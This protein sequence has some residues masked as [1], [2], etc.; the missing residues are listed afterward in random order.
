MALTRLELETRPF[1]N[2]RPFGS[3]GPYDRLEGTA[4]FALDPNHPLNQVIVDLEL[5]P[6]GDDGRV[7]FTADFV[8]LRPRETARANGRLL[9]DIPNR[10]RPTALRMLD[11]RP[12]DPSPLGE[13]R[14][15]DGWLLQR[16]YTL[17]CCGWQHDVPA[18]QGLIGIQAPFALE[19]GQPIKG[20]VMCEFQP[21]VPANVQVLASEMA[22][23]AHTPYPTADVDDPTATLTERDYAFGPPR[24]IERDRW[25]FA[26]PD[27]D[28]VVP[29]PTRVYFADGF[30]PGKRYEVVYTTSGSPVTGVGFAA[31]RD[32][33]SFLR[34]A[35][36]SQG[37]PCAGSLRS[38]YAFGASQS[39]RFL[40]HLLYLGLCEDEEGRL[41]FDGLLPHIGGG[42]MTEANWRF[43]Q[44]S[45]LGPCSVINLFPFSDVEQTEP[46]TGVTDGVQSR[47]AARGKLPKVIYTNSSAEYWGSQA[48]LLHT[49]LKTSAD[50]AV[51][52]YTRIYAFAGTQH[53]GAPLPLTDSQPYNA[54]RAAYPL[55]SINYW[56]LVRAALVNLD[57]WVCDGVDPPPSRHPRVDERTA[58]D[59]SSLRK[60]FARLP[61]VSLPQRLQ[62]AAR[63][64]Y[65]AETRQGRAVRLP[66]N[67]AETYP[68]LV[69]NV[70]GDG[71]EVAGIRHPEVEVPLATYTGWNGRHP[72]IGGADQ[73]LF[74]AGSTL[75]FPRTATEREASQDPRPSIAERYPDQDAYVNRV[76]AAA[77]KLVSDRYLLEE[78]V[79]P[80]VR[81]AARRYIELTG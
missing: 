23:T 41:A 55:N 78:D 15:G 36:A 38:V 13:L 57:A 66:P 2:G 21:N 74:L 54:N 33:A 6:A 17:V 24:V 4:H 37:N 42:R 64:D 31:T 68:A 47:A 22:G 8:M 77:R 49:D 45:Y 16:G 32:M 34:F 35:P 25:R 44:P 10:G 58:V 70:D 80:I 52:D 65:G 20:K 79:G 14:A 46:T 53:V 62:P 56:P 5:A 39:G 71:N 73:A 1:E 60:E 11:I 19:G 81:D 26:R 51:P 69:S 50:V 18:G 12:A 72:Q 67:M 40:R 9:V 63:L 48:G 61:N 3:T 43:G 76:E 75:P 27:R 30:K 29:D 59:R 28:R 7:H